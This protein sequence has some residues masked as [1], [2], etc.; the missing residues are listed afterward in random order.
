V[1]LLPDAS[2]GMY[3][4]EQR[5]IEDYLT[6]R[7]EEN[8]WLWGFDS[9]ILV[10][11]GDE[12]AAK[13]QQESADV[14][15][16]NREDLVPVIRRIGTASEGIVSSQ[17]LRERAS[18]VTTHMGSLS[19]CQVDYRGELLREVGAIDALLSTLFELRSRIMRKST[20][21][22]VGTRDEARE[23]VH[24]LA[25][26]SWKALRELACGSIGNRTAIRMYDQ[27]GAING[28]E[29][30]VSYL[31]VYHEV[32]W[33]TLNATELNLVTAVIGVLRNVT[34]KTPENCEPL[35]DY[36]VAPLLIWRLL[37]GLEGG[38]ATELPD[39]NQPWREACFR[40][41]GTL[42]NLTE[43]HTPCLELCS[44]NPVLVAVL[45][46]SWGANKR[47]SQVL[48]DLLESAKAKLPADEYLPAWEELI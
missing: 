32:P 8:G 36:G 45:V 30:L 9:D 26:V 14:V 38:A 19:L 12:S 46:D 15:A 17:N 41:A 16:W 44:T 24:L 20:T 37:D 33:H 23:E 18:L 48:H 29:L 27:N 31:E 3:S 42:L 40:C 7:E 21:P 28:L 6:C 34:H 13:S 25:T 5:H 1:R 39:Q 4:F 22:M 35:F 47:L 11:D 10:D 43:E 2:G